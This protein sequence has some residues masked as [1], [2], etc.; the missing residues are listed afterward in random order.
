[1]KLLRMYW[2]LNRDFYYRDKW[3]EETAIECMANLGFDYE[4]QRLEKYLGIK[5]K[6]KKTNIWA[7]MK[8]YNIHVIISDNDTLK[9]K[10]LKE[11]IHITHWREQDTLE[12]AINAFSVGKILKF[13][14]FY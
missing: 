5:N 3:D 9:L 11:Q 6:D 10:E 8:F 7:I 12:F 14:R 2:G 4:L 1:M 13:I